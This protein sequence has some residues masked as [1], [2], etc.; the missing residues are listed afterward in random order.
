MT[1]RVDRPTELPD[2]PRW[3]PVA[4][5]TETSGLHPDDGARVSVVIVSWMEADGDVEVRV[6][7]FDQGTRDKVP[8][9]SLNLFSGG[10]DPNLGQHEWEH[11]LR[12][13]Q[14]RRLVFHN[15]K[16]D[17]H[18]LR[19]GTRHYE[20]TDL[21][22]GLWWD[23]MLVAKEIEPTGS[24]ALS[25]CC[26]RASLDT[27]KALNQERMLATVKAL[28]IKGVGT[29]TNPRYDLASWEM[30]EIYARG[31]GADT[32]R[33]YHWQ[34]AVVAE[35]WAVP[36]RIR[37]EMRLLRVLYRMETRGLGFDAAGALQTGDDLMARRAEVGRDLPFKPTEH[38]A[39][40]YFFPGGEGAYKTTEKGTA[41]M[42]EETRRALRTKGVRW[43]QEWDLHEKIGTAVSMWYW[44]Y[45]G[46]VGPDG[47]L[48]TTFKQTFVKSGRLSVERVQLH[49]IPKDSPDGSQK[50]LPGTPSIRSFFVAREGHRLW[51]LDLS[52]AELRAAAKMAGCRLMLEMLAS[53]TDFHGVTT[54]EVFAISE[55]HPEWKQKRD[56]AKRLTFGSIFN[57]GAETFQ[58]TLAQQ[59]DVHWTIG[60]CKDAVQRW[61]GLYPEFQR[62]YYRCQDVADRRGWIGMVGD[63]KAWFGPRDYTNTAW[64]RKVQGSLAIFMKHWLIDAEA[65]SNGGLLLTVHDSVVLELGSAE[66]VPGGE[67]GALVHPVAAEVARRAEQA[68]TSLFGTPMRVDVSE[69]R[70]AL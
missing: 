11:L 48:R 3:M 58:K 61:R 60:A 36:K 22:Q 59:A 8:Q 26:A 64:S 54:K 18:M 32:I 7:P 57:I 30:M 46:M 25:Q 52:Q 50:G 23:T 56:I 5:D 37:R 4:V 29:K 31:D 6:F 40:A 67:D 28:K 65:N 62:A 55:G 10:E 20:G 33:L 39:R 47:R 16:F 49:A 9:M 12:W 19:A 38:G 43:A 34:R 44:G 2:L 14:G 1:S 51:N 53:G 42:D 70:K 66:L 17:L 69:W 15:A 63:E 41:S 13:L 45:P 21:V 68:A 35:G 27:A 24:L